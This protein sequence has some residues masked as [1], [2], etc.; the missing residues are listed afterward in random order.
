MSASKAPNEKREAV[1]KIEQRTT[2]EI[3]FHSDL[4]PGQRYI[5]FDSSLHESAPVYVA[6]RKVDELVDFSREYVEPHVHDVDSLYLFIGV[7]RDLAGLRAIVTVE[8]RDYAIEAPTTVFIPAGLKHYYRL[9]SG[10][11]L[12][13][14]MVLS[15]D[16]NSS[17]RAPA[18]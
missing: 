12:F 4:A 6:V 18:E 13:L 7:G 11:G 2:S 3:K 8:D 15:G 1:V 17:T 16:Y 10:S 9:T 5:A 14:S